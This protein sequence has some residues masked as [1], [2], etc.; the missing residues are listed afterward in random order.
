MSRFTSWWHAHSGRIA[1]DA[2]V[3]WLSLII[4]STLAACGNDNK[5]QAS[6]PPPPA[7]N[8]EPRYLSPP[9]GNRSAYYAAFQ[10]CDDGITAPALCRCI[11][12]KLSERPDAAK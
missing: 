10:A 12:A 7:S 8:L 1:T 5:K 6:A 9:I 3:L 11:A 4:I 2:S